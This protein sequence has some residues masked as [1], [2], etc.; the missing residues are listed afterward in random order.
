MS[1]KKTTEISILVPLFNE[2]EVFHS[3]IERLQNVIN[4]AT[5]ECSVYLI[6]DGST[7]KTDDL[8]NEICAIDNRFIG[9]HLSRNFGHQHAVSAGLSVCD[10][11]KGA[12]IIDGDLQDPPE[13]IHQF[14]ELLSVGNDVVYAVRKNRKESF[15]KRLVYKL[16]Y[17]LQKRISNFN[18]PIDSGDFSMISRRVINQLNN[19]PEKDLYYR[20]MRSW[21]GFKQVPFE[22]ERNERLAGESKYSLKLLFNLAYKGIFNFSD[23]P[24]QFIT[25]LGFFSVFISLLYFGY[26]LY[27]KLFYNDIPQGF[28]A[29]ILAIILFSGVQLISLGVI[30][31]YLLRIFKQV[32][33]RP[34]F[35]IDKI[36]TKDNFEI[37]NKA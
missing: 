29:T 24:I 27:R 2:D 22:Y 10:G 20:G 23:F 31:Q 9:V 25:R 17:R 35:I 18:I 15:F 12:M 28:T 34:L 30:G 26:N 21:V 33:N 5:F 11:T 19:M 3:L 36:V 8:I 4:D 1:K 14:Y 32:Q 37:K 7:D 6:N 16:Y 13:L